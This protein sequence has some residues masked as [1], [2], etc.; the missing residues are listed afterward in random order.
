MERTA[1]SVACAWHS[2]IG[3]DRWRS[4]PATSELHDGVS[5]GG[6]A[7][8]TRGEALEL[9]MFSSS[10]RTAA[11]QH[12][13]RPRPMRDRGVEGS[14]TRWRELGPGSRHV[15]TGTRSDRGDQP[16]GRI[17]TRRARLETTRNQ[18]RLERGKIK[19]Y[20][21]RAPVSAAAQADGSRMASRARSAASPIAAALLGL[22]L[23]PL[24]RRPTTP[25]D[26]KQHRPPTC[27]RKSRGPRRSC[28][29]CGLG[30][31]DRRASSQEQA[32][33]RG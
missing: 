3:L 4:R 28:S 24:A 16:L 22:A 12:R 8:G 15:P 33:P 6:E 20:E 1:R 29:L 13:S 2:V 19:S 27:L 32:I 30:S 10:R 17:C 31:S 11:P 18:S 23:R 5:H 21:P 25:S 9:E 7:R 26:D 14:S